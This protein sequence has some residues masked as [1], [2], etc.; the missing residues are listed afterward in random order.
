MEN[1]FGQTG[2]RSDQNSEAAKRDPIAEATMTVK[3]N[4]SH[5]LY[6]T[7]HALNIKSGQTKQIAAH[8]I[9]PSLLLEQSTTWVF[10]VARV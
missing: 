8:S 10:D 2:D 5:L 4:L 9:Q 6:Q 1:T 3:A 7:Y